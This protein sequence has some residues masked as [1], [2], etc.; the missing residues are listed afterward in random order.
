MVPSGPWSVLR[1]VP[2]PPQME[3]S[4]RISGSQ[5]VTD[6]TCVLVGCTIDRIFI[7]FRDR[8]RGLPN[9][10]DVNAEDVWFQWV[11]WCEPFIE[12]TWWRDD[13][14][15]IETSETSLLRMIPFTF[16]SLVILLC[17]ASI[18]LVKVWIYDEENWWFP[19]QCPLFKQSKRGLSSSH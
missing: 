5:D 18:M 3:K 17:L 6:R 8:S 7:L 2:V 10:F 12:W 14:V 15:R 1:M 13:K 19:A 4:W 9:G 16:L 11:G